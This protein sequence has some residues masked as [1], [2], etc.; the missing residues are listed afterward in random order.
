MAFPNAKKHRPSRRKLGKGQTRMVPPVTVT[1]TDSTTTV[2]LTFSVPVIVTGN[3]PL[4]V[5]GGLTLVT[6]VITSPTVVTQTY[7][8]SVSAKTWS[9]NANDPSISTFQGGG[10]APASGTF[11]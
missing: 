8:A 5:S 9:I 10:V 2:T 6:Q 3:I 7:S 4:H 11:S 1:V